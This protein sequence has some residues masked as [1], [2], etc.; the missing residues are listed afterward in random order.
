MITVS[1]SQLLAR[2]LAISHYVNT[3]RIPHTHHNHRN[4]TIFNQYIRKVYQHRT[5]WCHTTVK[6]TRKREILIFRVFEITASLGPQAGFLL[7][8]HYTERFLIRQKNQLLQCILFTVVKV[9]QMRDKIG[10][11]STLSAAELPAVNPRW[12]TVPLAS[13]PP[14]PLPD[15]TI[16]AWSWRVAKFS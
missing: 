11:I 7:M 10:N 1:Q 16:P 4:C 3:H 15:N 12:V 5:S 2:Q 8:K 9:I 6:F 14:S 13:P